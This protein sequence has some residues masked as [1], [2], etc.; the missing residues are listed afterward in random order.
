MY[1]FMYMNITELI[2]EEIK[3]FNEGVGDSYAQKRFGIANQEQEF[4]K[5]FQQ[6]QQAQNNNPENGQLVGAIVDGKKERVQVY[7]NPKSLKNFEIGVR[8]VTD[9]RGNLYV[10]QHDKDFVHADFQQVLRTD[11]MDASAF[12]RWIRIGTDVFSASYG[13]SGEHQGIASEKTYDLEAYRQN[14]F[15]LHPFKFFIQ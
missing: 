3:C 12:V 5:Q 4:E 6:R 8:A 1:V 14:L 7:K 11:V 15:K 13:F 2:K 9:R 10:A